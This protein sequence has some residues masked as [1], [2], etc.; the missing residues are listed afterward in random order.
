MS[1]EGQKSAS[2]PPVNVRFRYSSLGG[3]FDE[4]IVPVK[5]AKHRLRRREQSSRP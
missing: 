1:G 2:D 5:D 4:R 3:E